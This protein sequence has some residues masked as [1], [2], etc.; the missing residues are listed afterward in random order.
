MKK[1]KLLKRFMDFERKKFM[2][3]KKFIFFLKFAI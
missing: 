1:F 2:D 3:L